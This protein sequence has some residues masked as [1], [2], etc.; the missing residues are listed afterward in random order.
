M[1]PPLP[2]LGGLVFTGKPALPRLSPGALLLIALLHLAVFFLLV[3]LD[4]VRPPAMLTTLSVSL[5]TPE[6]PPTVIPEKPAPEPPKP[7]VQPRRVPKKPAAP[8]IISAPPQPVAEE[9]V[10]AAAVAEPEPVPAPPAPAAAAPVKATPAPFSEP[11][12]DADYLANPPPAYPAISRRM[13]EEGRVLLRVHVSAD[14]KPEEVEVK[15]SSGSPRLDRAAREAVS[16]WRFVPARRGD[17]K[18]AA[19]V[20]VPIV[21]NLQ[22]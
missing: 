21:F 4:V 13:G 17:E 12:F 14:G 19:W 6:K 10:A 7:V 11:R 16:R 15:T 20:Q 22:N 3:S 2:P 18:I 1:N 5:I 8:P 9:V